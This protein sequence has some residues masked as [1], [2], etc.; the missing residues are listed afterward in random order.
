MTRTPME[1]FAMNLDMAS[2]MNE[3]AKPKNAANTS[4]PT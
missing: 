4:R 1:R 3:P 2:E